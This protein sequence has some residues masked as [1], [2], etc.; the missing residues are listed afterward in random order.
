MNAAIVIAWMDSAC[1]YRQR[2]F[3]AVLNYHELHFPDLPIV[4]GYSDPFS[5]AA[6]IND[7]VRRSD[8][9]VIL[10]VD[11]D[12][13]VA[14][15]RALEA[16]RLAGEAPGLVNPHD[17]YRYLDEA[18]TRRL[19]THEI[20]LPALIEGDCEAYGDGGTGNCAVFSRA[21]WEAV[22]G[23]DERF[24]V[25]GGD[26]GAF[27]FAT[28]LLVGKRRRLAGEVW[29]LWHPRHPDS[30]VGSSGYIAQWAILSE[31]IQAKTP[32]AMRR[33]VESR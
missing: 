7:G 11:P 8:A 12:S 25:W 1:P 6:A 3:R 19:L 5:R 20:P 9:D 26:D 16:I 27:A 21:T 10:Q 4:F 31:Y 29:H 28:G 23:F 24:G 33:V 15:D 14:P 18:A 30:V 13:F 32:K 22:G 2:A 17:R